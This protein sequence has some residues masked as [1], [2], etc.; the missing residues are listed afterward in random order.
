MAGLIPEGTESVQ[1]SSKEYDQLSG[2]SQPKESTSNSQPLHLQYARLNGLMFGDQG[3]GKVL[4]SPGYFS[5]VSSN[6]SLTRLLRRRR[7][8]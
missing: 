3:A 4:I 6:T 2:F 7:M 5:L 8:H 1:G